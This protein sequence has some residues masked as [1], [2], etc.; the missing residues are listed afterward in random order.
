MSFTPILPFG[1]SDGW[2]FLKASLTDQRAAYDSQIPTGAQIDLAGFRLRIASAKSPALLADDPDLLRVALQAFGLGETKP[3][4]GFVVA[5]LSKPTAGA[6]AAKAFADP[7]WHAM[8]QA[9]G[10]GGDTPRVAEPGFADEIAALWRIQ[11][12]E[13]AV[14]AADPAMRRALAFDR[15]TASLATAGFDAAQGW[16]R[17]AADPAIRPV[18]RQALGLGAAFDAAA[19]ARQGA[20]LAQAAAASLGIETVEGFT[21]DA[22]RDAALKA[23]FEAGRRPP[24]FS[25]TGRPGDGLTGWR[26]LQ[27]G[28][29]ARRDA[30]ALGGAETPALRRFAARIPAIA[31][32]AALVADKP[33]MRTALEAFGLGRMEPTDAFLTAVLESDPDDAGSFASRQADPRWREMAAVFGFGAGAGPRTAEFGFA[34]D[35]AARARIAAFEEAAGAR[36]G[37]LRVAL[38]VDRTLA[39]LAEAGLGAR[40]GWDRALANPTVAYAIGRGLRLGEDFAALPPAERTAKAQAAARALT[41]SDSI[42]AFARPLARDT[43]V[44]RYLEAD[45]TA[46]RPRGLGQPV[47]PLTGIAG[48]AYLQRTLPDQQASFAN[49]AGVRRETDYFRDRIATVRS[50]EDLVA[51]RRLLAV[52]LDAFGLGDEIDKRAFIEKALREGTENPRAMAARLSDPRWRDFAA[53]FGFG[54]GAGPQTAREGFA[55]GILARH[56]V[57][58]FEKAVGGID[59]GMRLALNFDREMAGYATGPLSETAVWFRVLGQPPLRTVF[60]KA[61]GLPATFS[62]LDVERQAA[63]LRERTRRVAGGGIA[64]LADPAKRETLLR[65]FLVAEQLGDAVGA[66]ARSLSALSMLQA[67]PRLSVDRRS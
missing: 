2:A 26:A 31:D 17:A 30:L 63:V 28:L 33:M 13:K 53:A 67:M 1:G 62:T 44:R 50:A 52:A 24:P 22:A 15:A 48:W 19:P 49:S 4:A 23:F 10:Y 9:F 3:K 27:G 57:R 60:E 56:R 29:A 25:P 54:D 59:E 38:I 55:D 16:E 7:R 61:F 5:Q 32:A 34:E 35:F 58:S 46:E 21:T 20:M 43:L 65:R 45:P 66:N 41:G 12:F 64:A 39:T 8:A 36:D 51:D 18:L 37:D 14:G 40:E 47:L 42:D 11:G 6:D